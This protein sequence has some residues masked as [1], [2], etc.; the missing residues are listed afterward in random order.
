MFIIE[1]NSRRFGCL[2]RAARQPVEFTR[3]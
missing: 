3:I 2:Q 1:H